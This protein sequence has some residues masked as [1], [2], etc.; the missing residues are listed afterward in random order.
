MCSNEQHL[1]EMS[2][3]VDAPQE[4]LQEHCPF[5]QVGGPWAQEKML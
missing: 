1:N 2:D 4:A 3:R 5:T